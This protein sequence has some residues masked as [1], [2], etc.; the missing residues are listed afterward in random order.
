MEE[1]KKFGNEKYINEEYQSAIEFYD[2]AL[3]IDPDNYVLY[4]NKCASFL[5]LNKN[6]KALECAIKCTELKP[7]WPKGW[8]RLGSSLHQLGKTTDALTAFRKAHELDKDNE[9]NNK[10]INLLENDTEDESD[11]EDDV[12]ILDDKKTNIPNMSGMPRMPGMP[13]IQGMQGMQGIPKIPDPNSPQMMSMFSNMMKNKKFSEKMRDPKIQEKI[14]KGNKN[15]FEIMGDP[16]IMEMM[17]LM[18]TEL[19]KK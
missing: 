7:D 6:K 14:M 18:M 8:T 17:K 5:K 4:S 1:F 12:K 10:M 3:E 2:K 9:Y 13:G 19:P 16:D 11:E 15:P